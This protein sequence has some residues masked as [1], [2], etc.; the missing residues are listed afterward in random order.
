MS[1]NASTELT[2]HYT[3]QVTAD[4]ERNAKEQDRVS[5]E[6]A[7]LQEQ[8]AA[9][10][11]DHGVLVSIRQAIGSAPTPVRTAEPLEAVEPLE[12]A[13]PAGSVAVPAPRKKS[14]A[15]SGSRKRAQPKKSASQ[16]PARSAQKP[17]A[18]KRAA[19]KNDTA[20]KKDT[21][22]T[23]TARRET[24][25]EEAA[26]TAQPTLV[27]LVRDHLAQQSEPRS[28][29]EIA[30]ALGETH[31]ERTVKTTV[32]RTTLEGLVAKAL[33]QRTKQGSSVFYTAAD[34]SEAT[35]PAQAEKEPATADA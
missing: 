34:A 23:D 5:A 16:P 31:P 4:L 26:A 6:I 19:V 20:P 14:S 9:L 25:H 13:G 28:A 35:A 7:A 10:E 12:A 11:R 33:V 3:A 15:A 2:S 18:R 27:G 1:E 30:T 21:A 29:A 8:L 17:A 32:V 22:A 24:A